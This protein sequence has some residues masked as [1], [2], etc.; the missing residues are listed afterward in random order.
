[1]QTDL[2]KLTHSH[3]HVTT[4]FSTL[5][6]QH[7]ELQKH[8]S[9]ATEKIRDLTNQIIEAEASFQK[10][11]DIQKRVTELMDKRDKHR[12]QRMEEIETEWNSRR[13]ELEER[14]KAIDEELARERTRY[15]ELEKKLAETKAVLENVC[16]SNSGALD[17]ADEE[18]SAGDVTFGPNTPGSP[19]FR[20]QKGSGLPNRLSPAAAMVSQLQKGG[21]SLT[22]IYTEKIQLE[23]QMTDLK[24]ENLRLSECLATIMGEIQDKVCRAIEQ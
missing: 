3:H 22:Q 6:T 20:R 23:E 21:K 8:H 7:S 17:F 13:A 19:L 24:V 14:E 10:E 16:A 5:Q 11:I 1:M 4:S 2:D 12:G 9:D 15:E 18:H